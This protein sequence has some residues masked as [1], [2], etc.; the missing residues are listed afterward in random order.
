[1][2]NVNIKI[3]GLKELTEAI[4]LMASATAYKNDMVGTAE[5]ALDLAKDIVDKP[6]PTEK[7]NKKVET[8]SK[9][10]TAV[11]KKKDKKEEPAVEKEE[12]TKGTSLS[13]EEVR[14]ALVAKNSPSTRDQLKAI[15]DKYEAPNISQLKE[16]HFDAVMKELEEL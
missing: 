1:M 15:L 6:E 5:G 16:E 14:A 8:K 7:E 10:K 11:E 2:I 3:E 4:A 9:K 13:R 12:P